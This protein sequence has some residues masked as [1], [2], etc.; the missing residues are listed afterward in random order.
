MN[1]IF[2][3]NALSIKMSP[4]QY[5]KNITMTLLLVFSPINKVNLDLS[6]GT[7]EMETSNHVTI[8][9]VLVIYV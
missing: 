3:Y 5:N 1:Q 8:L 6:S 9:P 4:P 2:A 7:D